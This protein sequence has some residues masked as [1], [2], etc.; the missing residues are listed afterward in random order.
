LNDLLCQTTIEGK[1]A[2]FFYGII[3]VEHNT[4]VYSNAGHNPPMLFRTNG[5]ISYLNKGG[6]VLGFLPGHEYMQEEVAFQEGDVL[7]AYTDGITETTN[8]KEEEFGEE[9]LKSLILRNVDKSVHEIKD[10]IIN[11]LQIFSNT[12]HPTDDITL[13]I[14]KHL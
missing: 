3:N 4:L 6:I 7:V 8:D 2:T 1:Y 12:T 10:I 5:N 9:R 11:E 14:C 13:V